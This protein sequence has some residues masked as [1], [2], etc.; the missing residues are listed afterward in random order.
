MAIVEEDGWEYTGLQ[1]DGRSYVCSAYVA[2]A[3]KAAGLFGNFSIN[4]PEFT[5]RDVYTLDFFDKNFEKPKACQQV[6]PYQPFC[7]FLGKYRLTLPDYSTI[8]PYAN[9]SEKCATIAP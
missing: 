6:D 1:N 2:A 4:T 5:P 8:T 9:M 7:Q 3:Y